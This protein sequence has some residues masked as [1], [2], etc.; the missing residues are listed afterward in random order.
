[1]IH[2][3]NSKLVRDDLL[4]SANPAG[5]SR[6][7]CGGSVLEK[8]HVAP[9]G[10]P[11]GHPAPVQPETEIMKL[12]HICNSILFTIAVCL[13][14]HQALAGLHYWTGA[15]DGYWS[16]PGN[17]SSSSPP[18]VGESAPLIL[19]FQQGAARLT[20]TNDIQLSVDCLAIYDNYTFCGTGS[21]ATLDLPGNPVSFFGAPLANIECF[22]A[23]AVFD[24]SLGL[25]IDNTITITNA[26]GSTTEILSTMNGAGGW[27]FQGSGELLFDADTSV[28]GNLTGT[29]T[30]QAGLVVL[31]QW[32]YFWGYAIPV[33]NGPLVIGTTNTAVPAVL[34]EI[35]PD[36]DAGGQIGD[37]GTGTF[38]VTIL[39]SGVLQNYGVMEGGISSLTMTGGA[40]FLSHEPYTYGFIAA[41]RVTANTTVSGAPPFIESDAQGGVG[42]LYVQGTDVYPDFEGLFLYQQVQNGTNVPATINVASGSLNIYAPVFSQ[43][44]TNT[45]TVIK[46]GP[47]TLG[48]YGTNEYYA[49]TIIQQGLVVAG[50]DQPFGRGINSDWYNLPANSVVVSNGTEIITTSPLNCPVPL[51]LNGYG[52]NGSDGALLVQNDGAAFINVHLGSDSAVQVAN[53]SATA[54]FG[55]DSSEFGKYANGWYSYSPLDGS[56]NLHKLGPGSLQ[57][58][59]HYQT[60][61]ISG[62]TYVDQG[63][64]ALNGMTN[65]LGT[66]LTLINGPLVIGTNNGVASATVVLKS[67]EPISSVF[68]L[69]IYAGSELDILGTN[70]QTVGALTLNGSS[71]VG[72]TLVLNGDVTAQN[73]F[74][75]APDISST[76]SL[77]GTN[78]ALNVAYLSSLYVNNILDG[79]NGA[80]VK[81]TGLGDLD[82][83]GTNNCAGPTLVT[84]GRAQTLTSGAFAPTG[85]GVVVS[86]GAE[87]LL[88]DGVNIGA[89]PLWLTGAGSDNFGALKGFGTNSWA[90]TVTL[91]PGTTVDVVSNSAWPGSQLELSGVVTGSGGL[92]KL[93]WGNFL[94]DGSQSNNYAGPTLLQQGWLTLSKTNGGAIPGALTIGLGLDGTN[95]DI[96]RTL[97][98]QQLSQGNTVT[99]SSSGLLDLSAP[100]SYETD[101]GSLTGPGP[102][103]LGAN[104]LDCGYD[105]SST[106]YSGAIYGT[107]SGYL[108]KYGTGALTL[109]GSSSFP[110]IVQVEA[111]QAYINGSMPSAIASFATGG[112]LGGTGAVGP[113]GFTTGTLA[114]GCNGPGILSSG[115]LLLN[116]HD[117][118]L[119]RITGVWPGTYSELEVT[120]TIN[121]GNAT[122]QLAMSDLGIS[123]SV[124]TLIKNNG[125]SAVTGTFTNLP[126]GAT[127]A[128][129]SGAKFKISYKGGTGKDVVLTQTS[130]P[131][132]PDIA[133]VTRLTNGNITLSGSGAPNTTYHVQANTN[134]ASTNWLTIS[135]VTANNLG[136]LIWTDSQAGMYAQRF[137]RF[138]YP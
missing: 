34:R 103:Q 42:S 54:T 7:P 41:S 69:S 64:L 98:S 73:A 131:A 58:D 121:L 39:P 50:G 20:T 10:A 14:S 109:T 33:I 43:P 79:G 83:A 81:K 78:R 37:G 5:T 93:G 119:T 123:N 72:G 9:S 88:L 117:T 134:L 66:N 80:G 21:G 3:T 125:A 74:S 19:V 133:G 90:G 8:R 51:V 16:T 46:T 52:T 82:F 116:S 1:M 132:P 129:P 25:T 84:A 53:P 59:G 15:V 138:V 104:G 124:L 126:E 86:N 127:L 89:A 91:A 47:G 38:P 114:P 40:V 95:G 96:V 112:L 68:P 45:L 35:N 61:A 136:A 60:N 99:I 22:G 105:N 48:L 108:L 2:F 137:Y 113:F 28:Y 55:I 71:V 18:S 76:L 120:G 56:A 31:N 23:S 57:L 115:N 30:V 130:V 11:A 135:P 12:K 107:A 17:W 36:G 26:P 106:T 29:C 4:R 128:V 110:G 13:T 122:L 27:T 101:V 97:Q 111:G 65:Y 49:N 85:G 63:V 67:S 102:V 44:S 24:Y 100:F 75:Y 70:R 94:L 62:T 32:L 87:L 118:F 6:F 92:T 77:H